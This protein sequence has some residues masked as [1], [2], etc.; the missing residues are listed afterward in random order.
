MKKLRKLV[1]IL[2]VVF[3]LLIGV[4]I[5]LPILYKKKLVQY[6]KAELNE[7]LNARIQFAEDVDFNVFAKFPKVSV[8]LD[9]LTIIGIESFAGDTLFASTE[10]NATIQLMELI[11]NQRVVIDFMEAIDP[12]VNLI[13]KGDENNWDITLP[14]SSSEGSVAFSSGFEKI[15][16][17]HGNFSYTD[18]TEDIYLQFR[19]ITGN[20]SGK[21]THQDFD[22]KSMLDCKDAWLKFDNIPYINH[23]PLTVDAITHINLE[24][25]VYEF[26]ENSIWIGNLLLTADGGMR[27]TK[28]EAIDFD[29]KYASKNA[30]LDELL[31]LIPAYYKEELSGME[32]TGTASVSG[33]V[34]GLLNEVRYPGYDLNILL[35]NGTIKHHSFLNDFKNVNFHLDVSNADGRDNS[36]IINLKRLALVHGSEPVEAN[37]FLKS[38]YSDPFAKG[39]VRGKIDL[40]DV[41]KLMDIEGVTRLT[42]QV[43]CDLGFEGH[44]SSI[45]NEEYDQFKS[46][47]S[48]EATSI[49]YVS[50]DLPPVHLDKG[51]I[52]FT[53]THVSVPIVS[54]VVGKSDFLMNGNF[55]NFFGYLFKHE[56]LTGKLTVSSGLFDTNEFMGEEE[57]T[58][59]DSNAVIS[60]AIPGNLNLDVVYDFE[61]LVYGDYQ[62]EHLIGESRISDNTL[63]INQ[64]TTRFLGGLVSFKGLFRASKNE[65][66]FTDISM[67]VQD[68]PI[69]KVFSTPVLQKL[70]P[71]AEYAKGV[72]SSTFHF[73]SN[74][75]NDLTPQLSD[76][77]IEGVMNIFNCDIKGLKSF[78]ELA[79][80]LSY[81]AY[82]EP[83]TVRDLLLSFSVKDG[84]I[85][86][87]PF[88]LPIGETSLNLGGYSTL[89]RALHFDG[90]LT[91]PK[92]LY[93]R[94]ASSLNTYIPSQQ[95]NQID[96]IDFKNLELAVNIGG[97]FKDP[98][99]NLAYKTMTSS[100]KD[101]VKSRAKQELDKQKELLQKK[102]E[103]EMDRAKELA[104]Q[105]QDEAERKAREALDD[106]KKK[107]EEQIQKEKDAAHK[108]VENTL[109]K[110]RDELLK[111]SLPGIGG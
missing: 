34:K 23:I 20:F 77:T 63:N 45:E 81:D 82:A 101:R 104:K 83:V 30:N 97:H 31:S 12:T 29:L 58:T 16:L 28:D 9:S 13:A 36:L 79:Q 55:D 15:H 85:N 98:K 86:V 7:S 90:L 14:D 59:S 8:G 88:D 87:E 2:V 24:N 71:V 54:A 22:L 42:G 107:I 69:E 102:A 91:I 108:E 25:D 43:L 74:L 53:S 64:L 48:I 47:G 50:N 75:S 89:E 110:K 99:V 65:A 35:N 32:S 27:F 73:K 52:D 94:N 1:T 80:K 111:R 105:A 70:A 41:S 57:S 66:P 49:D 106:Q 51:E 44:Y 37:L 72:F 92:Q 62:F 33:S 61:N 84:K 67:T 5:A 10:V 100:I 4:A 39:N 40:A 17:A 93:L 109:K 56:D 60:I 18:S 38:I 78:N 76:I 6:V 3:V 95:L 96:S 26:R 11:R 68:L 19:D 46:S 21:L 103:A